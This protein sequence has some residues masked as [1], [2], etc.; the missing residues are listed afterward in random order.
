MA[1]L[2]ALTF[3]VSFGIIMLIM[4]THQARVSDLLAVQ[5]TNFMTVSTL[6]NYAKKNSSTDASSTGDNSGSEKDY[7]LN[8]LFAANGASYQSQE[9]PNA[10]NYINIEANTVYN[11]MFPS[12]SSLYQWQLSEESSQIFAQHKGDVK[13]VFSQ[14]KALRLQCL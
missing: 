7:P 13:L 8:N 4:T 5:Q 3:C 1:Q 2:L 11:Q 6:I 12:K 9:I 14:I 10:L